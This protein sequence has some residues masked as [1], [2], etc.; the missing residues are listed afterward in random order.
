MTSS[1]PFS[2]VV[3]LAP[4]FLVLLIAEGCAVQETR[5]YL[6]TPESPHWP[7]A[8]SKGK[9][10][11]PP[12]T[13]LLAVD[14]P[15]YL[16]RSQIVTRSH[17]RLHLAEHDRWAEPLRDN[18]ARVI[19]EDLAGLCPGSRIV[20]SAATDKGITAFQIYE[21]EID[22][23]LPRESTATNPPSLEKPPSGIPDY[24]IAVEILRFD[25]GDEPIQGTVDNPPLLFDAI[26]TLWTGGGQKILVMRR[27]KR[28]MACGGALYDSIAE[29]GSGCLADFSSELAEV[30]REMSNTPAP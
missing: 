15:G 19:A 16:D 29:A 20:H 6:L 14:I 10:E 3:A 12:M 25:H 23:G 18:I 5:F 21:E 4:C 30:I 28:A 11:I 26:W 7:L 9:S 1:R 24:R 27:S 13:V 8:K 22:L 17:N 2:A